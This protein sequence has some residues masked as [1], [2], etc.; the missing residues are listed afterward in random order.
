MRYS[1]GDE[2]P[3][4]YA[5]ERSSLADLVVILV[6]CALLVGALLTTNG[7]RCIM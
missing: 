4:H 2:E 5:R 3:T 6:W 7:P 1:W